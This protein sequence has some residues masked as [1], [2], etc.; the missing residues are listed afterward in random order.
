MIRNKL[1]S[2]LIRD[3]GSVISHNQLHTLYKD[4]EGY[5]TIGYGRLLEEKLSGGIS[6]GEARYLLTN[7]IDS[8]KRQVINSFSYYYS[9]PEPVQR[10]IINMCFNLGLPRLK[11]FVKMHRALG[12]GDYTTAAKEALDSKWAG[13][14][15]DRAQRIADLFISVVKD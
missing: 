2:D 8:C 12:I 3:E 4:S 11:K 13:Q 15:G 14:V 9:A 6:E 7:D 1:I 5:Y 10:G